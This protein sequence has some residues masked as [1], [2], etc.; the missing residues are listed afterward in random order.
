VAAGATSATFAIATAAVTASTLTTLTATY[1]GTSKTATIR[2]DLPAPAPA[3]V[4]KVALSKS[5]VLGGRPLT[6]TVILAS[7]APA[8]G[9]VVS[10]RSLNTSVFTVPAHVTVPAGA[11]SQAFTITTLRQTKNTGT[12]VYASYAGSQAYAVLKVLAP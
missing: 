11:T 8:G 6:A 3:A 1:R 5:S 10:L 2:V 7:A 9:I 12:A 4:K